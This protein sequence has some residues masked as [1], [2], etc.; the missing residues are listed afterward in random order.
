MTGQA[1]PLEHLSPGY[2]ALVMASGIVSV[3]CAQRGWAVASLLLLGLAS[4]A[5]V[6]L[7][8]LNL[9]RLAR[10]RSAMAAD[11][12]NPRTG[13][14]FFTFVAATDVLAVAIAGHGPV[15]PG[16]VLLAVAAT[17]WAILGYVV[18]AAVVLGNPQRPIIRSANGSW[19][20][21]VVA[22]QSVAVASATL[23]P[24]FPAARQWLAIVAVLSWSVGVMLYAATALFLSLRLLVYPLE[25][26]ELDPAYWI[27][28]GAVAITV[29][30]G[31]RI[32]E[33]DSAPMVDA[34]RGLVAGLAVL[35]WCFATWL[36]PALVG[37]G[38]WRH[39][40]H[41][42]PL[43]YTPAWWSIVFPLGMY[44]VAGMYLGRADRLPIVE[45][46]GTTWMWVAVAAWSAAF[47]A[48]V[49]S[50]VS[51]VRRRPVPSR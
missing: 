35:M 4:V 9:V 11:V 44:G 51:A 30:A 10:H 21:W 3:G 50:W 38:V 8:A 23:E 22:S 49:A 31:A 19:L 47:V 26:H 13:F 45:W 34:V 17:V 40:V 7:V 41:R 1:S 2:F 48:M 5:Y 16:A 24:H 6:T 36:I 42:D 25:P 32:V 29:V 39:V 18:P 33:M 20:V 43:H 27:S 12:R 14:Q 46:I 28:M 37:A 15:G